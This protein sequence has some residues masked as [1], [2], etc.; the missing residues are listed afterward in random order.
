[1]GMEIRERNGS[2]KEIADQMDLSLVYQPSVVERRETLSFSF[3]D[4][5]LVQIFLNGIFIVFGDL[6]VREKMLEMRASNFPQF[7]ELHFSLKG[8]CVME[9]RIGGQ[10]YISKGNQHNIFYMPAFD[11]RGYYDTEMGYQFFE[12]HFTR[13]KFMELVADSSTGLQRFADK[14][15]HGEFAQMAIENKPISPAMHACIHEILNCKY[16]GGLKQMFLQSKCVELL[17]LQVESLEGTLPESGR[18]VI[19]S[20]YDRDCIYQAKDYLLS[21]LELPPSIS[22]LAR[23]AGINEF[24]LK[25]GFKEIFNNSVFGYLSDHKLDKAKTLLH[26]G[27]AIKS[28]ADDLGYSSVQHFGTAFR[29]KYGISPGKIRQQ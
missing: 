7:V 16:T 25:N 6:L 9:N 24:K 8:N 10:K 2:W 19:K 17:V 18:K 1:M 22:E 13:D 4:A 3:G 11:G 5:Q 12:V 14:V 23:E 15:E 26:A 21:H 27:V 28:V 20:A 29:K